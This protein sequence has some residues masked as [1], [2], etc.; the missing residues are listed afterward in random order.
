MNSALNFANIS[1]SGEVTS[2]FISTPLPH[3]T[4][5]SSSSSTYSSQISTS[6]V[7][8]SSS[9]LALSSRLNIA[10]LKTGSVTTIHSDSSLKM[11]SKNDSSMFS[12]N[13]SPSSTST[14]AKTSKQSRLLKLLFSSSSQI[15]ATVTETLSRLASK[16]VNDKINVTKS[17]FNSDRNPVSPLAQ[18]IIFPSTPIN[19]IDK[20]ISQTTTQ[21][22][23][24]LRNETT[25]TVAATI[26]KS[27]SH[28][29]TTSSYV[30]KNKSF[31][32]MS[33]SL[34]Q[35]HVASSLLKSQSGIPGE[36]SPPTF[37]G[38]S[39]NPSNPS[40]KN[41]SFISA[42]VDLSRLQ[43]SIP[44]LGSAVHFSVPFNGKSKVKHNS[45]P[46][47]PTM[48]SVSNNSDILMS[49]S[50]PR[51]SY[52]SESPFMSNFLSVQSHATETVK[53]SPSSTSVKNHILNSFSLTIP[54]Q[55]TIDSSS[56]FGQS[57][58]TSIPL[59][60][61]TSSDASLI[62]K[63]QSSQLITNTHSKYTIN[64]QLLKTP[65]SKALSGQSTVTGVPTQSNISSSNNLLNN[66]DVSSRQLNSTVEEST[67][68]SRVKKT[69]HSISMSGQS[70]VGNIV[71]PSS[72]ANDVLLHTFVSSEQSSKTVESS[73]TN[74]IFQ[75][76]LDSKS[77]SGQSIIT[78][79][80][81]HSLSSSNVSPSI[82]NTFVI[83]PQIASTVKESANN[84]SFQKTLFSPSI[85]SVM[86]NS[87]GTL[88]VLIQPS[89]N[90]KILQLS[91]V[92]KS[93]TKMTGKM[94]TSFSSASNE[95][96]NAS[97]ITSFS[98]PSYTKM[99]SKTQW[100]G[101]SLTNA[102]HPKTSELFSLK[103]SATFSSSTY[104]KFFFSTLASRNLL[105]TPSLAASSNTSTVLL[106]T[107]LL[108]PTWKS[109]SLTS[110]SNNA[111]AA[112]ALPNGPP[113]AGKING[114]KCSGMKSS[115]FCFNATLIVLKQLK[116]HVCV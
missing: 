109:V 77:L 89:R 69:L 4:L 2:G 63:F 82:K 53:S 64:P 54:S 85:S 62:S 36:S 94:S 112:T 5:I 32:T 45:N 68:N 79:N 40:K 27:S 8:D 13:V 51:N 78:D 38:N 57:A 29:H 39:M 50:S 116:L 47:Q 113:A 91:S 86:S 101:S 99:L 87:S 59:Q 25:S 96:V 115:L 31:E 93:T 3:Q 35:S 28:A 30:F 111:S 17:S 110:E 72:S 66:T 100:N 11:Y 24:S 90:T 76:I 42:S 34:F 75:T 26:S 44:N 67:T 18:K 1:S 55:S 92:G 95:F 74:V 65:H 21:S 48:Y 81:I 106:T 88:K 20:V 58:A 61:S 6:V 9:V 56:T 12:F 49:H 23:S 15:S 52:T 37:H 97:S 103:A 107:T 98:S 33:S 70:T 22:L 10:D 7:A 84:S 102:L 43:R 41:I 73:A 16:D 105:S 104:D 83:S 108:T 60:S 46:S 71:N 14:N 80:N 19:T 114:P